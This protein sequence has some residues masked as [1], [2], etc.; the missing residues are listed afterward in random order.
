MRQNI[1]PILKYRGGK[2]KELKYYLKY[3]PSCDTYFEP[4]LGGGATFFALNPAKTYIADINVRLIDFYR[5]A[6][7]QQAFSTL[8]SKL[9][10]NVYLLGML[11]K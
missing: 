11:D 7:F 8:K 9:A 1:R 5:Y 4:F 3:I 2:A 6:D 10:K